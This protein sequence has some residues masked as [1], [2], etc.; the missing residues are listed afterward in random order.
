MKRLLFIL[1]I[2]TLLSAQWQQFERIRVDSMKSLTDSKPVYVNDT[3]SVL[4][5]K[6]ANGASAGLFLTTDANGFASWASL[7]AVGSSAG[8]WTQGASKV[9][10]STPTQGVHIRAASGDTTL[11]YLLNVYGGAYARQLNVRDSVIVGDTSTFATTG[12]L[13][14]LHSD[15]G[16][17]SPLRTYLSPQSGGTDNTTITVPHRTATMALMDASNTGAFGISGAF[18]G[19]SLT[20]TGGVTVGTLLKSD[21]LQSNTDS[22][23]VYVNDTLAFDVP[24]AG[25]YILLG[26]PTRSMR[27]R[28]SAVVTSTTAFH[29]V[30]VNTSTVPA[31]DY[32]TVTVGSLAQTAFMTSSNASSS[33]RIY[34]RPPSAASAER[35]L[36]LTGDTGSTAGDTRLRLSLGTQTV[37]LGGD[38]GITDTAANVYTFADFLPHSTG[39][40]LGSSTLPFSRTRTD[41]ISAPDG[42]LQV[43]DSVNVAGSGTFSDDVAVNGGD[44]TSTATT[45]NLLNS[46]VTTLNIAGAGAVKVG[47]TSDSAAAQTFFG[48][49]LGRSGVG[50]GDHK[51]SHSTATATTGVVRF[52]SWHNG[53][54]AAD[55]DGGY[56]SLN[57]SPDGGTTSTELARI[58][59]T[60]R[61]APNTG[62]MTLSIVDEG[63]VANKVVIDS[64]GVTFGSGTPMSGTVP[65]FA[66]TGTFASGLS[67][68]DGTNSGTATLGA[69]DSVQVTV[70]GVTANCIVMATYNSSTALAATDIALAVGNRQTNKFTIFGT[71][72]KSVMYWVAKK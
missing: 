67:S 30:G 57:N 45:F 22:Q 31:T 2:P 17:T 53:G 26:S 42:A 60:K 50:G 4:R 56:I 61:G 29:L 62:R 3:L 40:N 69:G 37:G 70:T 68:F 72:G 33:Y 24:S 48:P 58:T 5:F 7:T 32:D 21:T 66:S 65:I 39:K 46:T 49:V 52:D 14:L 43:V 12:I 47:R 19:A 11:T 44:L 64:N 71:N 18:T 41:S 1:L 16:A 51:F 35:A 54:T 20:T 13:G 15:D 9:Y 28:N 63:S 36:F 25:P 23:P 38:L 6:Y 8:G 55:G 34:Y 10:T 27:I 59:W